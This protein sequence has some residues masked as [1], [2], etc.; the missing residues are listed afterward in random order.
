LSTVKA[1]VPTSIWK[2]AVPTIIGNVIYALAAMAQTRFVGTLGP[3]AVAAVGVSQRVFFAV[4]AVL[5]AISVGASALIARAWGAGDR[6]EAA[7]VLTAAMVLT[8]AL[9]LVAT[10]LALV[11]AESIAASFGLD[12]STS[13]EA[14][15]NVR[16]FAL[17]M[18][19]LASN[20]IMLAALRATADV[21][22]PLLF[23]IIVNVMTVVMLYIF[24]FGAFGAPR[25]DSAGAPFASGLSYTIGGAVLLAAWWRQR[26]SIAFDVSEWRQR[27]RYW[28]LFHI[29]YPTGIEQIIMQGGLF[30][31]LSLIGHSYGKDAFAAYTVGINLLNV[32]IVVGF[33]FS[34]AGATLVG[35]H[36]GAGNFKAARR[37][38]WRS[39]SFAAGSMALLAVVPAVFAEELARFFL[40]EEEQAV[41][42]T[43]QF[44]YILALMLPLLGVEFAI[45]GS[46]RGAGD[47]R[48]PLMTT[49]LGIVF[50][51]IGLTL[52]IVRL[53]LPVMWAYSV[54]VVEYLFKATLLILRFRSGRWQ[55]ALA[56]RLGSPD[57]DP[58]L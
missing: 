12:A 26:L 13:I 48:F 2:L 51:R 27:E 36:L 28:R 18:L 10:I 8:G 22:I 31:F 34:I 23:V 1:A 56:G 35:Q 7:H 14:T 9:S 29:A 11:F 3:Q 17:F 43:V 33:G 52:V 39:L 46:L 24:I 15:R 38:G 5:I 21:W 37:S 54:M 19:G 49:I 58:K 32:A 53:G 55:H 50:A 44:T 30:V 41:R 42:Y 4:Q 57:L 25:M 40:G 6:R 20:I 16:W 47:T 45:G